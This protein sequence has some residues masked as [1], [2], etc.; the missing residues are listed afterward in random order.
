MFIR[1]LLICLAVFAYSQESVEFLADDVTKSGSIITAKGNV[2]AYSKNYF[3]SAGSAKFNQDE[4]ILE[5]YEN[6]NLIRSSGEMVRSNYA[7]IDLNTNNIDFEETFVVNQFSEIWMQSK[8]VC[9]DEARISTEKSRISSCNV[10][11]PDWHIEYSSGYMNKQTKFIHIFNPVFYVG[12]VPVLYL[13]YFGFSADKTRRTGLLPPSLSFHRSDGFTIIQPFYIAEY[14][15]WDLEFDPQIRTKRGSGIYST[16]RF[17][18]SPYSSGFVRGGVFRE[19]KE[20]QQKEELK[21]Q[22]HKGYKIKY[23]RNK[24]VKHIIDGDYQEN[25]WLEYTTLNDI[26]YLNLR[27]NKEEFNKNSLIQSKLNYFISTDEHYLGTYA[28]YYLDTAKIGTQYENDTT[29]QEL[30]IVQYHSYFDRFLTKHFTYSFDTKY[31]NYTRKVGVKAE[32]FEASLPLGI[33]FFLPV[34][35]ANLSFTEN[36]YANRVNYKNT[37]NGDESEDYFRGYRK[38]SLNSDFAGV[39]AGLYHTMGFRIDY[40]KPD[41]KFGNLSDTLVSKEGIVE[42]NFISEL[43]E[44]Y[45]TENIN[46]TFVQFFYNSEGKKF[47]RHILSGGYN[48]YHKQGN[49]IEHQVDLYFDAF[50]LYNKFV[51]SNLYNDYTKVISGLNANIYALNLDISHNYKKEFQ[52]Q[53]IYSKYDYL[54]ADANLK[55][56]KQYSI[57]GSIEYDNELN[58]TKM[59]R[60]GLSHNRKCWNYAITYKK[61]IEP[62]NTSYGPDSRKSQGVYLSFGFYPLGGFDYDFSAESAN[63]GSL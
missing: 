14:D 35:V 36:L 18:D 47:L 20:Y 6:V 28:K 58:Y 3:A 32:Q 11:D 52:T 60:A 48:Y 42:N 53:Q 43:S 22:T 41:G 56:P 33:N 16:F 51:F 26:D 54:K 12:S 8:S 17:A 29:L 31:H 5:L 44:I 62:K 49:D 38:I 37:I 59:W 9:S 4:K 10:M 57:F 1:I 39:L 63:E 23:N 34:N 7:K 61:D 2:L 19:T 13:P 25:L 21:N 15:E 30:P 40:I 50:K 46:A 45:T 55:L 27:G 24:L